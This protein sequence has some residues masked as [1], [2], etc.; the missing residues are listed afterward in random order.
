ME[1]PIYMDYHS[2]TP[3]DPAVREAMLP[4]L[5]EVFGN[6]ASQTHPFGWEAGKAVD[7]ARE[8]VAAFI[9]AEPGEIIF[10]GGATESNNLALKGVWEAY[11]GKASH[12][13]TQQTEHKSVLETCKYLEKCGARVTYLPVDS[14]GRVRVEDLREQIADD[15]LLISV[16]AANNEIGTFQ[17]IREIGNLAKEKGIFFHVD[18]AQA[19]GKIPLNVTDLGIDLLSWTAHKMYGPKGIG[20]LYLRKKN[21]RVRL[22]PVI[23]GGSH[24]QG[25]RSGTLNVPAIAGFAKACGIARDR[26]GEEN[27]RIKNLR[28]RLQLGLQQRLKHVRV[29]GHPQERLPGNL[30][31]SFAFVEAEG[32]LMGLNREIAISA[33]SACTSGSTE[34]SHV[35]KALKVPR[36]YMHGAVRFGLGRFTVSEEVDYA[37]DKVVSVVNKL[38]AMSPFYEESTDQ[39][40]SF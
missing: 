8:Q 20:A 28:D 40:S 36:D 29:N 33:S 10:T 24:E 37:L 19:S 26:M 2:T 13:I 27:Q 30:N 18:A 4:Y 7:K 12:I 35:L 1:F 34:P 22:I 5:G 6:P 21:P 23:H 38:R 16:M 15:T 9:G 11:K 3:V 32:L 31:I 25:I 17:P 14:H 39:A